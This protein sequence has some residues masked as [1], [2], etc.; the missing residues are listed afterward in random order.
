MLNSPF[1]RST[2]Q[3]PI[4]ASLLHLYCSLILTTILIGFRS[5]PGLL[6]FRNQPVFIQV[7][8]DEV[9]ASF[10]PLPIGPQ[11]FLVEHYVLE[12]S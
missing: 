10:F 11:L 7:I 4:K 2:E 9:R 8:E 3:Q 5:W 6:Y 1:N 12:G